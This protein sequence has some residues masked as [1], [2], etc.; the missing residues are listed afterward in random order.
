MNSIFAKKNKI[1]LLSQSGF[2]LIESLVAISILLIAVTGPLTLA[3]KSLAYA[4]YAKDEITGFY[5]AR[6]AIDAVRNIRD[7]NLRDAQLAELNRSPYGV[8]Q[9]IKASGSSPDN[10]KTLDEL[11]NSGCSV[12]V[13]NNPPDLRDSFADTDVFLVK[14]CNVDGSILYGHT[15]NSMNNASGN[16]CLEENLKDTIFSRSVIVQAVESGPTIEEIRVIVRVWWNARSGAERSVTIS[17]NF[18]NQGSNNFPPAGTP[19]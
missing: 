3:S 15:F 19:I 10:I 16:P 5:L 17:D 18:F 4:T 1:S 6:E 9:W 8:N 7:A 13:W 2:T 14:S 11:C 12:D